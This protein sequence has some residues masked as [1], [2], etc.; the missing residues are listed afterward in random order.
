MITF[1][2]LDRRILNGAERD[3]ALECV[4][5]PARRGHYE[6][7]AACVMPDHVHLLFEPQVKSEDVEGDPVFYSLAELLQNIKSV[8]AH[9]ICASR[10]VR[11]K[12]W[13][14]ESFDYLIRSERDLEEKFGY[15]CSNP[16][17]AGVAGPN[18]KYRWLWTW[19]EQEA[20]GES[21]DAARESR[22]L[23]K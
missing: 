17:N 6:L 10:H 11:G 1:S 2:T 18:E 16:W 12:V 23:P 8:S 3:I 15:I 5:Y 20:S 7:Y 14:M 21:P 13:E 4:L 19:D 9:K 22:A